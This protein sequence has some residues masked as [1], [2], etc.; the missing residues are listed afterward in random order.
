M[1]AGGEG[2]VFLGAFCFEA[3][4]SPVCWYSLRD[5]GGMCI[6]YNRDGYS[7]SECTD[8]SPRLA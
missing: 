8:W 2:W 7:G 3:R 1:R 6:Y 5:M 4:R